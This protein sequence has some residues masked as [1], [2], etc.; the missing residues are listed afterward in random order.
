MLAYSVAPWGAVA[1]RSRT[2]ALR[3]KS[4]P[5]AIQ[6]ESR[7]PSTASLAFPSS[8][9]LS[10]PLYFTTSIQLW[11]P[12]VSLYLSLPNVAQLPN[13][14]LASPPLVRRLIVIRAIAFI[15]KW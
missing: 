2:A 14:P 10:T 13:L 12:T 9:S 6:S 1:Q 8:L 5:A 11:S 7:L 4:A 15:Y 3:Q